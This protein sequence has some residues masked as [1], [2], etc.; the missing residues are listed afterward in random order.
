MTANPLSRKD[1]ARHAQLDKDLERYYDEALHSTT[2]Q[3][4]RSQARRKSYA[5]AIAWKRARLSGRYKDYFKNPLPMGEPDV[6][7]LY[8]A[9]GGA[10]GLAIWA[11]L[12]KPAN[13]VQTSSS[14]LSTVASLAVLE[15]KR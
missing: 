11:L 12:N 10:V 5:S 6:L 8:L 7:I 4:Y 15:K 14:L 13:P 9:A 3:H 1:Y 2:V